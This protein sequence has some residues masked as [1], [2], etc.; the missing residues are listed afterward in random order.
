MKCWGGD[1]STPGKLSLYVT[2]TN[3]TRHQQMNFWYINWSLSITPHCCSPSSSIPDV[4]SFSSL[5]PLYC[6]PLLPATIS[7]PLRFLSSIHPWAAASINPKPAQTPASKQTSAQKR[8]ANVVCTTTEQVSLWKVFLFLSSLSPVQHR[9][10]GE[11][12]WRSGV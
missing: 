6:W 8:S 1:R 10:G 2:D 5:W 7:W 11:H 9:S 12:P 3:Q 4:W